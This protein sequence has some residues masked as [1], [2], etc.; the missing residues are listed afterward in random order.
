MGGRLRIN[1]QRLLTT[2]W[3]KSQESS[4]LES[5]SRLKKDAVYSSLSLYSGLGFMEKVEVFDF[6]TCF[7]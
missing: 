5:K 7:L 1:F 3:F 4:Q 2:N 6:K